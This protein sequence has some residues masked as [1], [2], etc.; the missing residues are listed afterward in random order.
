MK[1]Q[2]LLFATQQEFRPIQRRCYQIRWRK[3][4]NF[5]SAKPCR[6]CLPC[7]SLRQT[8]QWSRRPPPRVSLYVVELLSIIQNATHRIIHFIC[9]IKPRPS[10]ILAISG[11]NVSRTFE[12]QDLDF[13]LH[14]ISESERGRF[15]TWGSLEK[16]PFTE[17]GQTSQCSFLAVSKPIFASTCSLHDLRTSNFCSPF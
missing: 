14:F 6:P 10:W 13:F 9:T 8:L 3:R 4:S 1:F 7:H 12:K 15:P 5:A 11:W 16:H 2:N 17:N